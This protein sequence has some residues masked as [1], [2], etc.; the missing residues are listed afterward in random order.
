MS[1]NSGNGDCIKKS[2][3]TRKQ[4]VRFARKCHHHGRARAYL[5]ENCKR[6]HIT[7]ERFFGHGKSKQ[8]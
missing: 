7:T 8:N 4:A 2:Y 6:W 5:C 1:G 3:G